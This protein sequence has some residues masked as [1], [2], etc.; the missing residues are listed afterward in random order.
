M[1]GDV[2][3]VPCWDSLPLSLWCPPYNPASWLLQI[4]ICLKNKAKFPLKVRGP[5]SLGD[6]QRHFQG[7]DAKA[8]TGQPTKPVLPVLCVQTPSGFGIREELGTQLSA[9]LMWKLRDTLMLNVHP[10]SLSAICT[11]RWRIALMRNLLECVSCG[12]GSQIT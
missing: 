9:G 10:G 8:E 7:Q 5:P 3:P 6:R 2:A 4:L 1:F 11:L 12:G